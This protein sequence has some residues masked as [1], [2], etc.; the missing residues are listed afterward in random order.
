M[1][2]ISPALMRLRVSG[3]GLVGKAEM[4]AARHGQCAIEFR[5]GG[6]ARKHA[7]LRTSRRGYCVGDPPRQF[8]RNR[9][10]IAGT[11]KPLIPIWSPER[12]SAAA[13]GTLMIF[14]D[15]SEF[16]TR[17]VVLGVSDRH[18]APPRIT[19]PAAILNVCERGHV[20]PV[21]PFLFVSIVVIRSWELG[22]SDVESVCLTMSKARTKKLYT[23]FIGALMGQ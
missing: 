2:S 13:S 5:A 3:I 20:A 17:A 9:L 6:S 1:Y 7:D 12:I 18:R 19:V 14:E 10:G 4:N 21:F 15:S 22:K 8:H 16:K 11:V 23:M